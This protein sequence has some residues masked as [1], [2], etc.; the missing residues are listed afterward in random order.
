MLFSVHGGAI[1]S[2]PVKPP[3][4]GRPAW[5][6]GAAVLAAGLAVLTLLSFLPVLRNDFVLLDDQSYLTANPHVLQGFTLENLSWAFT[7]YHMGNWH[8]VTWIS[9]LIDGRL[10]GLDPVGHHATSLLLHLATTVLLFLLVRG[11]TGAL[12]R[13][14]LVA[15][16]FAVH[17]L[18]VE[19]VAW[20]SERKDVLAGFFW[21]LTMGAYL[22]YARRPGAGRYVPV[23]G[24]FALGLMSKASL[25]TLPFVLLLVDYWPLGRWRPDPGDPSRRG[26]VRSAGRLLLEKLPLLACAAAASV[27]AYRAQHESGAVIFLAENTLA[28]RIGNAAASYLLYLEKTFWPDNLSVF[29]P[30]H[31]QRRSLWVAGAI[32]I[33]VTALA[34][35]TARSRPYLI[36]GWLW[37]AVTL[38]PMIGLVQVG[39]QGIA[40]RYTY[41]PLIGVFLMATWGAADLVRRK[42]GLR[43]AAAAGAGIL[44]LVLCARSFRQAE[45][46]RSTVTLFRQAA[47]VDP[48]NYRADVLVG[49]GLTKEGKLEEANEWLRAA[50]RI[51]PRLKQLNS[52]IGLNLY[53]RGRFEEAAACLLE[54]TRVDPGS[55]RPHTNLGVI[56]TKLGRPEEAR[57]HYQEALRLDPGAASVAPPR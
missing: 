35:R 32:L 8:P 42:A 5:R 48:E 56:F 23:L 20:A 21:V 33:A 24:C 6:N 14:A 22:R 52:M 45:Y 54:E 25:V 9:H 57:R 34:L 38:V 2:E 4:V 27:I 51:N 17:P 3:R 39:S 41:L 26:L 37:F 50:L 40:D 43:R 55:A 13:G 47:A 28:A 36:A 29:Y 18:H 16:L 31:V 30:F 53:A 11:M 15:A 7:T 46:W 10:F 19:S 44:L 49:M 1:V 12:W